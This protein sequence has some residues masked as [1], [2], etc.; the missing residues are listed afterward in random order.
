MNRTCTVAPALAVVG[1]MIAAAVRPLPAAAQP[2]AAPA[3]QPPTESGSLPAP[4]PLSIDPEAKRLAQAAG[5]YLKTAK[6]F[7]VKAEVWQ[8]LALPNGSLVQMSRTVT[9]DVRR[10]DRLHATVNAPERRDREYWYDGKSLTV[11][12]RDQNLYGQVSAPATIDATVDALAEKYGITFPLLDFA[13]SDPAGSALR[14]VKGAVNAGTDTVLGVACDH[15]LFT[16]EAVDWQVWIERGS[17]PFVKKLVITYK[18]APGAPRYTALLSDW[19][20][21]PRLSDD[22]FAFKPPPGSGRIEVAERSKE[23]DGDGEPPAA[24]VA[25][26]TEPEKKP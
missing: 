23:G 22:L 18:N 12:D 9:L 7:T 14:N 20:R 11:L 13:V 8:D 26:P 6:S 21:D 10:P 1:L 3:A 24:P 16:Q 15:L 25:A 4:V 2:P 19:K 5:D 17:R